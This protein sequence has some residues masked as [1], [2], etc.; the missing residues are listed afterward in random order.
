MLLLGRLT[1]LSGDKKS[2]DSVAKLSG[3]RDGAE[4]GEGLEGLKME[5]E[6]DLLLEEAEDGPLSMAVACTGNGGSGATGADGRVDAGVESFRR[7]RLQKDDLET[8]VSAKIMSISNLGVLSREALVFVVGL[9]FFNFLLL[10]FSFS[11]PKECS[12]DGQ[13]SFHFSFDL[14]CI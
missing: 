7:R 3:G 11:I 10:S 8:R 9:R 13:P 6:L 2:G 12:S 4:E 1:L 14:L 5:W